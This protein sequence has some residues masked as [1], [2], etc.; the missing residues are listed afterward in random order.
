MVLFFLK[1]TKSVDRKLTTFHRTFHKYRNHFAKVKPLKTKQLNMKILLISIYIVFSITGLTQPM[2]NETAITFT[3]GDGQTVAAYKGTFEV[4]ENRQ[5]NNGKTLSLHYVRF[6][7]THKKPGSPI[8]YLAGGPGGS[9]IETAK[10]S[11]FD[12]FMAMREVADV[13]AFDQ[14]GTGDS[15]T[16]P[17]CRSNQYIP[18]D[19]P[20]SDEE[21]IALNQTALKECFEF[22]QN[23][24]IDYAAYTTPE[25]VA[26]LND[27]RIHLGAE[28]ISLW[29]ISYGTHLA[30]AAMKTMSDKL[31][32]V[33]IASAE[34]LDQTI[35]YPART[36]AYFGRLQTAL[37]QSSKNPETI[38]DIR[39]LMSRIHKKLDEQPQLISWQEGDE[40][41]NYFLQARDMK[42]LVAGSI[43]DPSN[44]KRILMLYLAVDAGITAPV[45]GIIQKYLNPK[46][47]IKFKLMS[48]VMDLASGISQS[49]RNLIEKQAQTALLGGYLNFTLY[50]TDIAHELG[51]DLGDEFRKNPKSDVPTLLFSGTLDGRTYIESQLEAVSDFSQLTKITVQNAGH[52]LFKSSPKVIETMLKFMHD[53]PITE[54]VITVDTP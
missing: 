16:L 2:K 12:L 54:L 5:K 7:S 42:Q 34:G 6:P 33:I 50:F 39:A 35:K 52:N 45:A 32:K 22:W 1:A 29:G 49:R 14:R 11:R 51:L 24:D 37:N 28:K 13:I 53:Q 27:L 15:D 8:I 18:N 25:S 40:T 48:V 36:D 26:D 44:A 43:A 17:E 3:S 19:R 41:I 23:N 10:Y 20:I 30:M 46:E 47:P 21:Y 4:T 9:G 31:D 38:T